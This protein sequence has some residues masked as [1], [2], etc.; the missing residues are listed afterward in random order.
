MCSRNETHEVVVGELR[1]PW[2]IP[3]PTGILS[4]SLLTGLPSLGGLMS[5]HGGIPRSAV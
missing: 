3:E 1:E 4:I 5:V 2:E